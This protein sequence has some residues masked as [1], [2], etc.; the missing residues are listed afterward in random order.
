M[1]TKHLPFIWYLFLYSSPLKISVKIKNNE[2]K[3]D[4]DY[5]DS[6]INSK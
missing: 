5:I 1:Y 4:D 3:W 6:M 2:L